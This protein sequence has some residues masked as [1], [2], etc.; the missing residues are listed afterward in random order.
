MKLDL[1]YER[2]WEFLPFKLLPFK[3]VNTDNDDIKLVLYD[4]S[5]IIDW[6]KGSNG[7]GYA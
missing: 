4:V 5:L 6:T 1:D 7:I 3:V 2:S